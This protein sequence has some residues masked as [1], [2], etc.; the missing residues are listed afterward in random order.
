MTDLKSA[1][2]AAEMANGVRYSEQ[3]GGEL[4]IQA[5]PSIAIFQ[6][7]GTAALRVPR[8]YQLVAACWVV[9]RHRNGLRKSI[10]I[11]RRRAVPIT[12]SRGT[13]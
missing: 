1:N 9:I 10:P 13:Q 3:L 12:R 5:T 6:V 7:L 11:F 2:P 4:R 8:R